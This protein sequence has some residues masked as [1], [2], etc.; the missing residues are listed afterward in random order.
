MLNCRDVAHEASDYIDHNQS[1][2]RRL[3]FRL[4][5]FI[6]HNCRVFVAHIQ[7]TREFIRKRGSTNASTEEIEKVMATVDRSER[8]ERQD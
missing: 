8:N 7:V 1:W 2:W 3:M 4:H 5:L 6:C